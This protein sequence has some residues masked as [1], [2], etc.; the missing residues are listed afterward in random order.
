LFIDH[1]VKQLVDIQ[2]VREWRW[3]CLSFQWRLQP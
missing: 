2:T 3:S 1:K